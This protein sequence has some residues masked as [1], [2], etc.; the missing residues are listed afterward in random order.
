M[1]ALMVQLPEMAFMLI[2]ALSLES[3]ATW[4][5]TVQALKGVSVLM[6]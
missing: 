4:C 3:H 1:V 2:E 5:P 6:A